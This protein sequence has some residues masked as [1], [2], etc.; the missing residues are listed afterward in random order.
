MR[1]SYRGKCSCGAIVQPGQGFVVGRRIACA[2]H[3]ATALG[4]RDEER[5][6]MREHDD[7]GMGWPI[8]GFDESY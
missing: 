8:Y 7:I 1:N 3:G 4:A 6:L 5:E 2:H